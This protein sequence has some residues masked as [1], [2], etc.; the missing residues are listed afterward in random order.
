MESINETPSND[1]DESEMFKRTPWGFRRRR[2]FRR[3][4][5]RTWGRRV[6]EKVKNFGEKVKNVGKKIHSGAKKVC[7][8]V[9]DSKHI[10]KSYSLRQKY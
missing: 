4:S 9:K 6:R 5:L 7:G 8:W 3:R 1:E 2:F 10:S